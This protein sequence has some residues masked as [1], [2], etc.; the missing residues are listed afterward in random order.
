MQSN[1]YQ[2]LSVLSAEV[3]AVGQVTAK[4]P[5]HVLKAD[6]WLGPYV[7]EDQ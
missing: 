5:L 7:E 6:A 1:M 3:W 2:L 4:E